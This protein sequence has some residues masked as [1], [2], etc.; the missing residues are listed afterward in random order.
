MYKGPRSF[1]SAARR[2]VLE[3]RVAQPIKSGSGPDR[4]L[5]TP[6][7]PEGVDRFLYGA[8]RQAVVLSLGL[9]FSEF[10]DFCTSA[11]ACRVDSS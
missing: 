4:R 6:Y 3:Q 9:T 5:G 10:R 7:H 1:C 11:S 2:L 8:R